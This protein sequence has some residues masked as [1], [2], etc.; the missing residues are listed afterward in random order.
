M[1]MGGACSTYERGSK[2]R[3]LVDKLEWGGAGTELRK[4]DVDSWTILRW[5]LNK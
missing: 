4:F 3:L 2:F 1:T 5:I